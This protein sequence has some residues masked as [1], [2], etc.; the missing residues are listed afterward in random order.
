[1]STDPVSRTRRILTLAADGCL[2]TAGTFAAMMG[3]AFILYWT[4]VAP[5]GEPGGSG[6]DLALSTFSWL[7]QVGGFLVGPVLAWWL[8]QGRP[9]RR[10]VVP[11][12]LGIVVGGAIVAPIAMLGSFLEWFVRLFSDVDYLGAIIYLIVLLLAFFAV[13]VWRTADAVR[14]MVA[15]SRQHPAL[16]VARL[17][18][19]AAVLAFAG[20]VIAKMIA[21][22]EAIEAF[23]FV[24][25]SGVQGAGALAVA[26]VASELFGKRT[27][28]DVAG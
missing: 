12:L 17:L 2:I 18:A 15:R 21:G 19:A 8:L 16:D 4:G 25:M 1:M 10:S 7:L 9:G 24:L 14:H 28:P 3:L 11:I 5:M 27:T 26:S 13:I 23:I 20:V 6:A 22:E